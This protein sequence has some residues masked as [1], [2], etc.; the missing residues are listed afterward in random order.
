MES[1]VS[2]VRPTEHAPWWN[3]LP[4]A[5]MCGGWLG[6]LLIFWLQVW[7]PLRPYAAAGPLS[8]APGPYALALLLCFAAAWTP[9]GYFRP[10]GWEVDGRVYHVL[11]VRAF[12]SLV[13]DGDVVNRMRRRRNPDFRVI[14][15]RRAAAAFVQRTIDSERWHG[16]LLL[17]GVVTSAYAW[18]I[19]WRGWAAFLGIGNLVVNLY[20]MLLQ[21]YTRARLHR[22]LSRPASSPP[23]E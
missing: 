4:F 5:V 20:P 13:P 17:P 8:P 10:R 22:L 15:D 18:Q 2:P 14:A 16:V 23:A 3:L 19:G 11:G 12:R 9:A 7:G 1:T 6:P 21:R